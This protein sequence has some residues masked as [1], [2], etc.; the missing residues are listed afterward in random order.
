MNI[1]CKELSE[2]DPLVLISNPTFGILLFILLALLLL[3]VAVFLLF[4]S[5]VFLLFFFSFLFICSNS[6][7]LRGLFIPVRITF[8]DPS[9]S[10]FTMPNFNDNA[11]FMGISFELLPPLFLFIL[12]LFNDAFLAF[13]KKE[14]PLLGAGFESPSGIKSSIPIRPGAEDRL[15][16][17]CK[18]LNF[19]LAFWSS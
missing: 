13:W 8:S 2:A 16:L 14:N 4:W 9:S 5:R 6:K 17:F 12:L 15:L 11:A 1:F 10:R 19:F 7:R 18:K 3:G